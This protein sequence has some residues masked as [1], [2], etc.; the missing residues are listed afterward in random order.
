MINQIYGNLLAFSCIFYFFDYF[1]FIYCHFANKL[2]SNIKDLLTDINFS[3]KNN[4]P[5]KNHTYF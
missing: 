4:P 1:K 2:M 5:A 3:V